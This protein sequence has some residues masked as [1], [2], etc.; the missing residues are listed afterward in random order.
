[1]T[2]NT[3]IPD[4]QTSAENDVFESAEVILLEEYKSFQRLL[5]M[6]EEKLENVESLT[7]AEI[8]ALLSG[9][10]T[11]IEGIKSLE[12][13]RSALPKEFQSYRKTQKKIGKLAEQL[14]LANDKLYERLR[15]EKMQ[16][17]KD[18][19]QL[20][21]YRNRDKATMTLTMD[22]EREHLIDIQQK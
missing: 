1:M 5:Q 7:I 18:L 16:I 8:A 22:E 2:H 11:E 20:A 21:D 17:A 4:H 14:N 15:L 6:T 13:L 19:T 10:E 12:E 9:R 3:G